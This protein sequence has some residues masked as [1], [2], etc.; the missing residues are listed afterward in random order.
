MSLFF[1]IDTATLQEENVNYHK[2][3]Y[4]SKVHLI[5]PYQNAMLCA[6]THKS[7]HT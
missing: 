2:A 6:A 7:Y 1:T 5:R 4:L 3:R